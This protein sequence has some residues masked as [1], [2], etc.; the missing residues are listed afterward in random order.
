MPNEKSPALEYS[1][2]VFDGVLDWYKNADSKAQVILTIDGAF[3]AFLTSSIFM[4]QNNLSKI[5]C[6]FGLETWLLLA[7]MCATLA[8]SILSAIFCLWSRVYGRDTLDDILSRGGLE[9][10]KPETYKPQFM[11]FFQ[12]LSRL[13]P[14]QMA[15]KLYAVNEKYEIE[16]LAYQTKNLSENV[17]NKH[18]WV[19]RGFVL[20]A[21]S[22]LLFLGGGVS[23]VVRIGV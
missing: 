23:Y 21:L 22:L 2:R 15:E 1:R 8:G 16:A 4:E 13:Q 12:F 6:R 19:N 5:L 11:F 20:A 14:E 10:N 7:L 17:M 9:V 3:L 18:H